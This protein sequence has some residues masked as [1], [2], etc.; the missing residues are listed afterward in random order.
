M[1]EEDIRKAVEP[2]LLEY[3][4]NGDCDEVLSQSQYTEELNHTYTNLG[5]QYSG[6]DAVKYRH[7][8]VK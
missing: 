4:D 5:A 3:F 6:G 8:K 2:L 1:S 7:S